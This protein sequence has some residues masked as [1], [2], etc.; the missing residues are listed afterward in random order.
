MSELISSLSLTQ[1]VGA[2]S[3]IVTAYGAYLWVKNKAVENAGKIT[4]LKETVKT[5]ETDNSKQE[6]LLV[7]HDH[8]IEMLEKNSDKF[9]KTIEAVNG[10][11]SEL[12]ATI[13]GLKVT[14]ENFK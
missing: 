11:L 1:I 6:I 5:L 2:I 4:E 3:A 13:T 8:K 9:D 10:T 7:K 14:V 12:N